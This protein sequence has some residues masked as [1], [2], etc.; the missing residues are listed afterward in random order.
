MIRHDLQWFIDRI[1][2]RIYRKPIKCVPGCK[3]CAKNY[4]DV[5]D[6][7]KD[8]KKVVNR[9]FHAYGLKI[10]QDELGIEYFDSHEAQV[11]N[12]FINEIKK[13]IIELFTTEKIVWVI[14]ITFTVPIILYEII[15]WLKHLS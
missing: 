11:W 12:T 3:S 7:T 13:L 4:V 9:T 8:G 2:K 5:W 6:G 14:I 1:G 10:H 15:E